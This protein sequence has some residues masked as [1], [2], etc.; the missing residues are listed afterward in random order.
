[1]NTEKVYFHVDMDAFFAAIEERDHPEYKGKC[2]VIGGLG[3]R[4]VVST[5][6]YAARKFGVHSAM[7]MGQALRL[8]P[9]AI[10]VQP[11]MKHYSQ[12][13]KGI[14]Q[15]CRTFSP[16]VQQ[17]SI[18]EAFLDMSGTRRL[19][20]LPREAAM[21]LKKKVTEETGLTISVGIAP[22]RFIAKMAS[23]YNKPDGLCRVSPGKEIAF[24]DAVG[25]KKLWGVGKVTRALLEKHHIMTTEQ[26]RGFTQ[27]TLQSLF[28]QSMGSFLYNAARGIDPGLFTCEAKS[29]SISSE[30]TFD[31]DISSASILEQ[32]LLQMSHEVMFRSLDE[33]Q[34]GR[35]IGIKVRLP[36]FTTYTCQTTPKAN[37]YSAEQIFSYSK[38]L[39]AQKWHEGI[40]IRLLGVGLY[41]LYEGDKP[42]QEEL[43][44]DPYS[45]KRELEKLILEMHKKGQNVFKATNLEQNEIKV[46]E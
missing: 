13:S 39:L 16:E 12:V 10:V 21:L 45:K 37:I 18:D 4:S 19:Y 1:M 17:L 15:I 8:C 6:S 44:E 28:G 35:T 43:F 2:L 41:Q 23:D 36:D 33:K 14:M 20:G 30:I 32:Y 26:L 31:E 24:I 11:N 3:P 7:P 5:A 9:S 40:P 29:H 42:M 27:S 25:L 34:I 46:K 38:Q 22:S